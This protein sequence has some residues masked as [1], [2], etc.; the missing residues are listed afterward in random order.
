MGLFFIKKEL[1]YSLC[2]ILLFSGCRCDYYR[3]ISKYNVTID[4]YVDVNNNHEMWLEIPK[5]KFRDCLY[6]INNKLNN[7]DYHIELVKGSDVSNNL[8]VIAGHSGNGGN[9]FFNDLVYLEVGDYVIV[10]VGNK[11]NIFVINNIYYKVKGINLEIERENKIYLVTCSKKYY[12]KQ[13]IIE[14]ILEGVNY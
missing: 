3:V 5:I 10:S 6:D 12:D 4:K 13:L 11:K 1:V 2:L 14:G 7:V 8:F 9:A